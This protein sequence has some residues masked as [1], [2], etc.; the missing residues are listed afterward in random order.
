MNLS[1]VLDYYNIMEPSIKPQH[2]TYDLYSIYL[3]PQHAAVDKGKAHN[4]AIMLIRIK[5]KKETLS[6]TYMDT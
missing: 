2:Y 4:H 1:N 3:E 6:H 5:F